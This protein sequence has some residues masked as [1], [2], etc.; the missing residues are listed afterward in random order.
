MAVSGG[1]GQVP[2]PA[3]GLVLQVVEDGAVRSAACALVECG[4]VS[5]ADSDLAYILNYS[6]GVAETRLGQSNGQKI[7]GVSHSFQHFCKTCVS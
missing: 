4:L 1:N 2:Y 7:T 5:D 3:F 6:H